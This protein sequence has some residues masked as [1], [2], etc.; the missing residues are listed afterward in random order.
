MRPAASV[1]TGR[2]TTGAPEREAGP[3]PARH[4]VTDADD[5]AVAR[6]LRVAG[7]GTEQGG[8]R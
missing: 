5:N 6:A 8:P 4:T 2:A 3:R 1:L 7:G